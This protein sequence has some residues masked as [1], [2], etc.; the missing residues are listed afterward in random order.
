MQLY[1]FFSVIRIKLEIMKFNNIFK[2]G[3]YIAVLLLLVSGCEFE[4]KLEGN[5]SITTKRIFVQDFTELDIDGVF[6]VYLKQED[7]FR[8]EVITDENLQ[9]LVE[10]DQI[11]DVLYIKTDEESDYQATQMDVYIS[12]PDISYINLEGVT[13]LYSEGTL[14]LSDLSVDK[15]NTGYLQLNIN[16]NK[17]TLNSYGSGDIELFGKANQTIIYNSMV[18]N[19]DAFNFI[20]NSMNLIHDGTGNIEIFV[21]ESLEIALTGVGDVYCKGN[22]ESITKSSEKMVGRLYL[23]D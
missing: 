21:L 20:T 2:L 11:S 9:Y 16:L 22:P 6:N 12:V 3:L 14:F 23:V 7:D 15:N 17:L 1:I 8:V 5:G 19:I 13:A 10:V 4:Q 18:G